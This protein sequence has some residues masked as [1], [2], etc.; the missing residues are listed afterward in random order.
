MAPRR[1]YIRPSPLLCV[2]GAVS[3][4]KFRV[5]LHM[6][7]RGLLLRWSCHR[8][9]TGS[10]KENKTNQIRSPPKGPRLLAALDSNT[11]TA[12]DRKRQSVTTV[13]L[14]SLFISFRTLPIPVP[15]FGRV[16]EN[17]G[18]CNCRGCHAGERSITPKPDAMW[19]A[20]STVSVLQAV[21]TYQ[22]LCQMS[23]LGSDC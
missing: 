4:V 18:D 20:G 21:T 17:A 2:W 3:M 14:N 6:Q 16:S 7:I 13:G 19:S 22:I 15:Q 23:C 9:H 1:H 10:Y 8:R 5:D 11:S 12:R